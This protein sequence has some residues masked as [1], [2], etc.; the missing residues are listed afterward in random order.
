MIPITQ[1]L[2][3]LLAPNAAAVANGR[4]ISQKGGFI[5][6]QKSDD[7]TFICGECSG[8]GKNP[9][10]TSADFAQPDSPVFRCTCPSRQFPCKHSIGLM[11]D[12]LAKKKFESCEIPADILSKREKKEQ[13]AQAKAEAIE[14]GEK[15]APKKTNTAALAKKMKKQLEGLDLAEQF[16]NDIINSGLSTI[17]GTSIKAYKDLSKQMG[18]YYLP[19]PQA[20]INAILIGMENLHDNPQNEDAYYRMVTDMIV[21]LQ[22]TIKKAR[23]FLSGK[24]DGGEV[25]MEDSTLYDKIGH[26]WQLAQL[27]ELG[28]YTDNAELIQ[29]S[30]YVEYDEARAEYIDTGYWI[31][32]ADGVISKKENLRPEKAVKYIKQDDTAFDCLMIPRLYFYPGEVNKRVRWD[33]FTTR[34]VTEDDIAKI[35]SV[36]KTDVDAVIK[37]VKN[38]IKNALSEKTAVYLTAFK[39]IGKADG[40]YIMETE[41]GTLIELTGAT[42]DNLPYVPDASMLENQALTSEFVYDPMTRRISVIPHSIVTDTNIIRLMY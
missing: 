8:S 32:P 42:A 28:L 3:G 14:S 7:D 12:Y 6:L 30:F 38:Q 16:I 10:V 19:G 25:M 27:D 9:Y 18:D 21:Q 29:L 22:S 26:V 20:M 34:S 17:T 37:E 36:A 13:K 5:K 35:R 39:K 41:N 23:V 1:D 4:K 31:N 40:K 15:P 24:V 11:F 2:I 33:S